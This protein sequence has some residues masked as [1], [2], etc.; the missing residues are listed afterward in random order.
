MFMI[1]CRL[2]LGHDVSFDDLYEYLVMQVA[3]R[4]VRGLG[5]RGVQV[6]QV[7]AAL[8]QQR[9][10]LVADVG[11]AALH[12]LQEALRVRELPVADPRALLLLGVPR[13]VRVLQ[14][15]AFPVLQ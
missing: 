12:A 14:R 15:H 9:G 2:V 4:A 8:G 10:Q 7:V 3:L 11:G 1:V 13:A 5:V 6:V